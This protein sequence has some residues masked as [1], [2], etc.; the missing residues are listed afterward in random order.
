[1]RQKRMCAN[2]S[3]VCQCIR[4][5]CGSCERRR[6]CQGALFGVVVTKSGGNCG[7]VVTKS[8]VSCGVVV[9]RGGGIE[10]KTA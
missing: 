5:A 6:G 8:D 4:G 3:A 10:Q 2:V 7:E 9:T 1:M